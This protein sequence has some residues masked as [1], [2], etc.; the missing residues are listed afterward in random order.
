MV[1]TVHITIMAMVVVMVMVMV[2][3]KIMKIIAPG[4][5]LLHG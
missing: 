5:A 2:T 3:D 4:I 1:I